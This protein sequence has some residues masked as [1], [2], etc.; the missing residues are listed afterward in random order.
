MKKEE[1]KL[2]YL[3]SFQQEYR[4]LEIFYR[5]ISSIAAN[6]LYPIKNKKAKQS[7]ATK[8]KIED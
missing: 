1:D 4:K 2:P 5:L 7:I 3:D 8:K 6:D